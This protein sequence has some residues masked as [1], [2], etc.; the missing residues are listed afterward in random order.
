MLFFLE[1]QSMNAV[2]I[3]QLAQK[4]KQHRLMMGTAESCTGGKLADY[5]TEIAG[6]SVWFDCALITY[7]YDAKEHLLG[8]Q[9]ST[10]NEQGAVSEACVLEMLNGLLAMPKVDV[11]VSISGI[12]GPDG[13]TLDKPVGTVWFAIG[14]KNA[15]PKTFLKIFAGNRADIR[16]AACE[17]AI[18]ELN[19]YLTVVK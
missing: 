10:L 13:G 8:V 5:L 2:A 3:E 9:A 18:D 14:M 17:F 12:A 16:E 1:L 19:K 7:S 6:A 11:G 4:L 15:P